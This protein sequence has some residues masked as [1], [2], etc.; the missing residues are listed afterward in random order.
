MFNRREIVGVGGSL[1][2]LSGFAGQAMAQAETATEAVEVDLGREVGGLDHI[3]QR[4]VGSDRAEITLRESWR[5]DAKRG[6]EELGL[7]RVRFHGV[8]DDEL[9]VGAKP[10]FGRVSPDFNFQNVDAVYDGLMDLGLRPYVEMSFMPGKLASGTRVFG[11][12]KANVTPPQSLPDWQDFVGQFARHLIERY[13]AAEVRQWNFEVWNEPNLASFWSGTQAD[14]F[15]FYRATATALKGVDPALKV[16]GPSTSAVQWIPE[17]LAFCAQNNLPIDFVST[18]VYA[19]D[20]QAR[21]FGQA[22]KFGQNAVIPAAMAQVRAQI[23]A[24]SFKGAELWL[25]EWSSDSPAMIAHVV[26]ACLPYCHAMSQW[27]LSGTYEEILT[28]S[29]IF[30]EGD[31]GWGLLS[32]GGVARPAFNT[33]KL[34]NRLGNRR[35]QASGPALATRRAGGGGAVLVWNLAEVQQP[36][37]IPGASS[38]RKVV[39]SPKRLHINLRG[40]RPGQTVKVSYVDQ[41]RGSPYP[42]WR[43]LGSPKYPTRQQMAKIRAAAELLPPEEL[44]LGKAGELLLDLPPEGVALIELA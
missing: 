26:T 14:Y 35:L 43:A 22:G 34:M 39:G 18:H 17:F 12:Y 1:L 13:G 15:E 37:G 25:S 42:M 2:A 36:A 11:N 3:W 31:N 32:R 27:Q 24:S 38:E 23:D 19:G 20:N 28:P 9:G 10:S 29:W 5:K 4:C 6:R 8:F 21:I 33:Y 44:K 16:G 41:A 40:A 7:E 30:K